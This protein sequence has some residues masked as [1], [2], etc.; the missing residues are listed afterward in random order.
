MNR[1]LECFVQR[2]VDIREAQ[3][4]EEENGRNLITIN[5]SNSSEHKTEQARL[6]CDFLMTTVRSVVSYEN[7]FFFLKVALNS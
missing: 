5:G 6:P 4:G 2:V 7:R 1:T 3:R